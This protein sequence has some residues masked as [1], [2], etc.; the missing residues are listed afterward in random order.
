MP[1]AKAYVEKALA[2]D[3]NLADAHATLASIK[4]YGDWDWVAANKEFGRAIEL[5]PSDA[6]FHRGYSDFLSEMGRHDQ[7]MQEVRIAQ[8]LDPLSDLTNLTVGWVFFYARQYDHALEQ[9]RKVLELDPHSVSAHE[10]IASTYLATGA[11]ERATAG[12]QDLAA[13][14]ENDPLRLTGLGC[15]YALAGKRAE[16]RKVLAQ[17]ELAS[18]S[19]YVAPFFLSLVHASLGDKSGAFAS[20]D[21]A[22][23]ARDSY[24]VRLKVE[25]ALDPLRS[26]PRFEKLLRRMNL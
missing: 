20:L 10:C 21:K 7:A 2:L 19:S 15:S 3:A 24:L 16:A 26:D 11:Y 14:S 22:F 9:C 25:P 4:F 13:I 18:K 23:T 5:S 8:D 1:K 17:L 12:Y 6:E